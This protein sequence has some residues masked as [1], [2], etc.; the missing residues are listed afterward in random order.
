MFTTLLE[1]LNVH[2]IVEVLTVLHVL[3]LIDFGVAKALQIATS[4]P[5]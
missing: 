2:T 1:A 4:K 3:K 5:F